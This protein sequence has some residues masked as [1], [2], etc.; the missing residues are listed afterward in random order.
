MRCPEPT[1]TA[2]SL[3]LQYYIIPAHEI[4][5]I[6]IQT[7]V[8]PRPINNP[9]RTHP[10]IPRS[11]TLLAQVCVSHIRRLHFRNTP[12][13]SITPSP[14]HIYRET[15]RN[16]STGRARRGHK[17]SRLIFDHLWHARACAARILCRP[18]I[19]YSTLSHTHICIVLPGF[20]LVLCA[21][22]LSLSS[23][24]TRRLPI[25]A[26]SGFAEV[27]VP[28]ACARETDR[29]FLSCYDAAGLVSRRAV[30]GGF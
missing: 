17:F 6:F 10:S 19:M 7:M 18:S 11:L 21:A 9:G 25:I 29:Y 26:A 5:R 14:T 23:S 30:Y 3:T 2:T 27:V 15:P 20:D 16:N 1:T 13:L 4:L 22:A 12:V 8:S 28:V 24:C